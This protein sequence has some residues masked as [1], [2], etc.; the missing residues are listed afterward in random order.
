MLDYFLKEKTERFLCL[1]K[2]D[3]V[4]ASHA[5]IRK[6]VQN[7]QMAKTVFLVFFGLQKSAVSTLCIANHFIDVLHFTVQVLSTYNGVSEVFRKNKKGVCY[8]PR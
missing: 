5:R 4:S 8:H 7:L 3:E 1:N 6:K 2:I